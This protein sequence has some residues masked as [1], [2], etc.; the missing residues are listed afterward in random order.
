M[1]AV[2]VLWTHEIR[3]GFWIPDLREHK[4]H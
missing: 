4:Q 1:D 3:G 2:G